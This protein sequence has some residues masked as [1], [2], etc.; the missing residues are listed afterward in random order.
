MR[1]ASDLAY[2]MNVL[3]ATLTVLEK[4]MIISVARG[5]MVLAGG[6]FMITW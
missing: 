5:V 4:E 2:G 6:A 1:S 3:V